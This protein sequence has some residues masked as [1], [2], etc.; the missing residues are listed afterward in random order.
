MVVPSQELQGF[1]SP[2][3]PGS[4]L[5][6]LSAEALFRGFLG[7]GDGSEAGIAKAG[8]ASELSRGATATIVEAQMSQLSPA[9]LLLKR[10]VDSKK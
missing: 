1:T 4:Q 9:L 7:A 10:N 5:R 3:S 8:A 6:S 2:R